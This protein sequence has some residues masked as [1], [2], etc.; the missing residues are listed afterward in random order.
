MLLAKRS[1]G[2]IAGCIALII[3]LIVL[4]SF[5]AGALG[6]GETGEVRD[7]RGFDSVSFGTSGEVIVVQGDQEVL[8]IV[9][10]AGDLPN[11]VTEVRGGTLYIG[12]KGPSFSFRPPLFRLTMKTVAGLE[13]RSSGKITANGLSAGALRIQISSSGGISVYSLEA[14]SLDVQISSSGSF[15]VSGRVERQDVRLSSSGSYLARNLESRTAKVNVSSSGSAIL[16]VS[17]SLEANV[18]SSGSVRYYGNPPSVNGNVTS[19]GRLIR[20]SD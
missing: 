16:R 18:T 7:V 1:W 13:T 6:I 17:E 5:S 12:R 14:D 3:A 20:L 9:A 11:I 15:D 2:S 4:A 10:R 19:S 8:E